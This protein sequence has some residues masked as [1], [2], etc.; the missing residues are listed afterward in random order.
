[1]IEEVA[2]FVD[3]DFLYPNYGLLRISR[4][5]RSNT[6]CFDMTSFSVLER[7]ETKVTGQQLFTLFTGPF[8]ELVL[9]Q[10]FSSKKGRCHF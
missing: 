9:S 1:M 7:A 10:I 6:S 4:L 8:R 2:S 3:L 5:S